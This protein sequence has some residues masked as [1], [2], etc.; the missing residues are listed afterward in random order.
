MS[1]KVKRESSVQIKRETS[2]PI[3]KEY[4]APGG[5]GQPPKR[6]TSQPEGPAEGKAAERVKILEGIISN[7]SRLQKRY[8]K[9]QGSN[10]KPKLPDLQAI[11]QSLANGLQPPVSP[12]EDGSCDPWA[13]SDETDH[14]VAHPA[15]TLNYEVMWHAGIPQGRLPC[16]LAAASDD[17]QDC[18]QVCN[19]CSG[20]PGSEDRA[21]T[22]CSYLPGF[23]L[24]ELG[25]L[26]Y[27]LENENLVKACLNCLV[28]GP[29]FAETC[30]TGD[31]AWVR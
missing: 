4:S 28:K 19:A 12:L 5:G 13:Q 20:G 8:K 10:I 24:D 22:D 25:D 26:C 2:T 31:P 6:P 3:K 21:F 30:S 16:A 1:P 27:D 11:A 9:K 17:V 18:D 29:L 15:L 14:P 7:H 23:G